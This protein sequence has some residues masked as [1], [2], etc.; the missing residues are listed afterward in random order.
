[1][2]VRAVQRRGIRA[3]TEASQILVLYYKV[4]KS[5]KGR[6]FLPFFYASPRSFRIFKRASVR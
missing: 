2:V 4:G 1:M 3:T 6:K 5:K